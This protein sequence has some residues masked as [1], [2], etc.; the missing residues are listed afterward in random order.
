MDLSQIIPQHLHYIVLD[1][2]LTMVSLSPMVADYVDGSEPLRVGCDIRDVFPELYGLE[3]IF[4]EIRTGD[5]PQFDVKAINRQLGTGMVYLDLYFRA[6][7]GNPA[8]QLLMFLEDVTDKMSLEQT[9]VQSN[10][11]T[12]LLLAALEHA[13]QYAETIIESIA[14]AKVQLPW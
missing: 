7:P 10:N 4:A 9:L 12:H 1:E 6:Y 13:K 8:P 11:E 3:D 5:R 2:T 14:E